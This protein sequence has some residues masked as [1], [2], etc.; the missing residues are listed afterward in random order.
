[1]YIHGLDSSPGL[2]AIFSDQDLTRKWQQASDYLSKVNS[3]IFPANF[4]GVLKYRMR[5]LPKVLEQWSNMMVYCF[6]KIAFEQF[7]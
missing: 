6:S 7:A 5:S 3:P 1:M 2:F 4:H